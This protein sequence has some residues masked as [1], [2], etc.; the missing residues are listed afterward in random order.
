M[1]LVY[2]AFALYL[3]ISFILKAWQLGQTPSDRTVA[4]S[5]F[6]YSILYLMFL[7][8][9]MAIDSL[10]ITHTAIAIVSQYLASIIS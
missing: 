1:G 5:V 8:I 2:A 10:P 4:R 3:G 9:G 7:C 6:K